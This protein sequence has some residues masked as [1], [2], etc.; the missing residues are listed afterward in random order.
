MYVGQAQDLGVSGAIRQAHMEQLN[1][2]ETLKDE[3]RI[4]E[5]AVGLCT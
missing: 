1:A 5:R 2:L 4:V 3:S